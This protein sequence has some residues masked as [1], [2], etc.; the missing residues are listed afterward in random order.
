MSGT[1]LTDVL[2]FLIDRIPAEGGLVVATLV[3][4]RSAL[5]V[6]LGVRLVVAGGGARFGS[7]HPVLDAALSVQAL[8]SL[9]RKQSHIRSFRLADGSAERTGLG[10]GDVDVYFE[11]LAS[12][13]RLVIVGAG[14]IAV[15]LARMGKLLDFEVVVVDDRPEYASHS[16]FPDADQIDVGPYRATLGKVPIDSD[17][18]I[19]LVTRGH[20]HDRAC[21]EQVIDSPAA[22]IGM[23]GSKRR[24]RTVIEQIR[25]SG[26]NEERL[27]RVRAPIGLDI[28][29]RTPA[30]IALAIMAEIIQVRRGGNAESLTIGERTRA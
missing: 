10:E 13:P 5:D 2:P 7:I 17:S 26:G 11:V 23:I 22:Y 29:S 18:Y 15:P 12:P 28:G 3:A 8:E 25:A 20:V 21:L 14:H 30:E 6:P 24:V 4:N 16:R 27:K 19:V 1:H 9:A